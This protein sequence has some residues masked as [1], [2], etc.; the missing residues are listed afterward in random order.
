MVKESIIKVV[1]GN[2]LLYREAK[3]LFMGILEAKISPPQVAALLTA[4]RMKGESIEEIRALA[5]V[6]RGKSLKLKVRSNILD[7]D[8]EDI[9]LDQETIIDTCGTGGKVTKTFNISTCTAFV[10]AA[11]GIKV[12]KHGNRSFSGICGSAD[13]VEGLGIRVDARPEQVEEA[14]KQIGIGFLYAPL[15][16]PAMRNVALIRKELGLRTIFNIVG[17]L[18]NPANASRQVL[19]VYDKG[20]TSK[21]ANV[22]K[23]LGLKRAFVVWGQDVCDEV[24]TTGFTQISELKKNKVDTYRLNPEDF[25]LEKSDISKIKGGTVEDNVESVL[26]VLRGEPSAKLDIVLANASL[27]LVLADKAKGFKEGVQLAREYIKNK[28]ALNKLEELKEF[29]SK[30]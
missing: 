19:G 12:A 27:C 22:L 20:L 1:E 24:S 7:I 4:L 13:V 11:A 29:M 6:M 15:Y 25:G 10:I 5:E 9:N 26:S 16:H 21:I 14:V 2:D 8:R 28:K 3:E 17:P 30:E 23:H 18:T